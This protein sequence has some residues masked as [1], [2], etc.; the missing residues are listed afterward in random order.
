MSGVFDRG[1]GVIGFGFPQ[2]PTVFT[3]PCT[4][5]WSLSLS[6]PYPAARVS[7]HGR[8]LSSWSFMSPFVPFERPVP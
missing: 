4:V 2:C 5:A 6:S 3:A 8:F 7:S 1:N